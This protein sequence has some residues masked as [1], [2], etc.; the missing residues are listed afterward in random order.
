MSRTAYLFE[1]RSVQSF[2]FEGGKL[3]DMVTASDQLDALCNEPL[4]HVLQ[5]CK[6]VEN[7]NIWFSR[8]A[9]GAVYAILDSLDKAK[10]L[11]ALWSFYVRKHFP[12]VEIVQVIETAETVHQAMTAALEKMAQQRNILTAQYPAPGPLVRRSPRTANPVTEW[13]DSRKEWNDSRKEWIDEAT[14]LK[15]K[16]KKT[17]DSLVPKFIPD[18]KNYIADQ[19]PINL[20]HDGGDFPFIKDDRNV[21]LVHADGNG[22]GELLMVLGKVVETIAGKANSE[23]ENSDLIYV[24]LFREFSNAMEEATK[25]AAQ[26]AMQTIFKTLPSD[27]EKI[28]ARPMVLG[29]D[30]L[31]ILIRADLA[32]PFASEFCS[33]FARQTEEKLAGLYTTVR[34][35]LG[36][37]TIEVKGQTY[38]INRLKSLTA[39]AGIAFIKSNQ[40]FLQ[41]HDLAEDLCK[42]A[43]R[44]SRHVLTDKHALIPASISF[45]QVSSALIEK[46]KEIKTHE[47]AISIKKD[48]SNE[49]TPNNTN[50]R[51]LAMGAYGLDADLP[52]FSHLQELASLFGDKGLNRSGLRQVAT[53]LKEDPDKAQQRYARWRDIEKSKQSKV[54]KEPL[55]DRYDQLISQLC[56]ISNPAEIP[57]DSTSLKSPLVDLLLLT[58][59]PKTPDAKGEAV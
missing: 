6:L 58:Y 45:H 7:D 42:E 21:A 23:E 35:Q 29:G 3:R 56:T 15:R 53:L 32:L 51:Y 17:K 4:S 31:T 11:R 48:E 2:I 34:E 26:D 43:K 18:G 47:W 27:A 20:E 1:T 22:I 57:F 12:G 13:D 39:C 55:L 30:D 36:S 41:A 9:G 50:T 49:N 37:D 52:A 40:P 59:L 8:K 25:A 44:Q 33:A 5:T 54:T 14:R 24:T 19:W 28:P 38:N 10:E 16:E 46:V